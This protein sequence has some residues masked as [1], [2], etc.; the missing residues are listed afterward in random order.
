[1]ILVFDGLDTCCGI[2]LGGEADEFS[3][4]AYTLA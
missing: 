3:Y 2:H 4:K 1:M